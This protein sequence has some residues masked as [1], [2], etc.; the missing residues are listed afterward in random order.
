MG[1]TFRSGRKSKTLVYILLPIHYA[2]HKLY[3]TSQKKNT[4]EKQCKTGWTQTETSV[5]EN[6]TYHTAQN[7]RSS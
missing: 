4:R 2:K 7:H 6:D 1:D 5:M 3:T